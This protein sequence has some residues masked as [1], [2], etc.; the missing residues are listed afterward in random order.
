MRTLVQMSITLHSVLQA[1][2][3]RG[4]PVHL[5]VSTDSRSPGLTAACTRTWLRSPANW[6]PTRPGQPLPPEPPQERPHCNTRT[7]VTTWRTALEHQLVSRGQ[8]VA[9]LHGTSTRG[10]FSEAQQCNSSTQYTEVNERIRNKE[11]TRGV[12]SRWRK[13]E[14]PRG[15]KGKQR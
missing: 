5:W 10:P 8:R 2:S 3:I 13:R 7:A 14:S 9:E 1:I 12:F 4:S 11:E 6:Q 15:T